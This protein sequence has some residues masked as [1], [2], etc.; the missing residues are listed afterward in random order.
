MHDN[1]F[2]DETFIVLDCNGE[3]W[4]RYCYNERQWLQLI[5]SQMRRLK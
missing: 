3:E 4:A 5:A 1:N 2:T